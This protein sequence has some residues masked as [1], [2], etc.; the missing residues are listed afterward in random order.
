M[1]NKE[2]ENMKEDQEKVELDT[3]DMDKVSGGVLVR[4]DG[5]YTDINR[6]EKSPIPPRPFFDGRNI[7]A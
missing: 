3:E 2:M 7:K 6:Q 1:E 5:R 4:D